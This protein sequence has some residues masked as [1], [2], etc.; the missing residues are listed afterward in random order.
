MK[1]EAFEARLL[2]E[3]DEVEEIALTL[4]DAGKP[5]LGKEALTLYS[6]TVAMDGLRLGEA[7]LS[8]IEAR[9]KVLYGIRE[10]KGEHINDQGGETVNCLVGQDPDKPPTQ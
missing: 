10:P 9:T 4:L 7:L 6:N 1:L 8:G 3:Q 2:E 5:D